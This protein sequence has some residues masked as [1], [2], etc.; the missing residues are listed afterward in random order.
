MCAQAGD[1]QH[2]LL[3][4]VSG[5]V[6]KASDSLSFKVTSTDASS[7]RQIYR[8]LLKHAPLW[9]ELAIDFWALPLVRSS[10]ASLHLHAPLPGAKKQGSHAAYYVAYL[11]RQGHDEL[12]FLQ[13]LRLLTF[14]RHKG[15]SLTPGRP[16]PHPIAVGV[17]FPFETLDN[18]YGA[19]LCIFVPHRNEAD[20][21]LPEPVAQ[22]L[23]A[24]LHFFWAAVRHPQFQGRPERLREVIHTDLLWRGC[25]EDRLQTWIENFDAK[26]SLALA[27]L[28]G[29]VEARAWT[30][31][32]RAFPVHFLV[33][34]APAMVNYRCYSLC[35]SLSPLS[36]CVLL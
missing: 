22:R 36:P 16:R 3:R 31:A 35:F 32:L 14:Q 23:P 24:V 17:T 19:Y 11:Q 9:Q 6:S 15:G 2:A 8:L 5:Y 21:L 25:T 13:W 26:T 34:S 27:A 30:V 1:S 12:C 28:R 7:W 20:F 10:W 33:T 18:Y 29:E 4:Y